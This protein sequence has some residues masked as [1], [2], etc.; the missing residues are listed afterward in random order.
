M[1][2]SGS[3]DERQQGKEDAQTKDDI[4]KPSAA[5][6]EQKVSEDAVFGPSRTSGAG[7]QFRAHPN[8]GKP[9]YHLN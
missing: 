7:C 9:V 1:F 8:T 6:A 5:A 3:T 2:V 4:L